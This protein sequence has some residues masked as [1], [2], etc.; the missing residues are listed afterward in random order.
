VGVRRLLVV[1][2]DGLT[3]I[4]PIAVAA[5]LAYQLSYHDQRSRAGL[6]S[7]LVLNRTVLTTEQLKSAF[8]Q[9]DAFDGPRA[10]SPQAVAVMRQIDLGSS[11]LQGVGHISDNSLQ[12]SSVADAGA[13]SVGPYDYVSATSTFFRRNRNLGINPSA[14]L[15]LVSDGSGSTGIIHPSLIFDLTDTGDTVPAGIVGYSTRENIIS[16]GTA[17]D[18]HGVSLPNGGAGGS[19]ELQGHL[20]AWN[21]SPISDAFSYAAIPLSAVT[22]EFDSLARYFVP[23]AVLVGLLGLLLVRR[24]AASY[25]SL[26]ML[27]KAGLKRGEVLTVYQP[28]VELATGRWVGAEALARWRRPNNEWVSPEV[29]VPIAERHGLIQKLTKH[30]IQTCAAQLA[31]FV[32]AHAN[33]FISINISS[34]DLRDPAFVSTLAETVAANG[35]ARRAIHLE[36]TERAEVESEVEAETIRTLRAMGFKVG[37]DDFGIGYSN[38]AYLDTLQVDY[39]KIDRAFVAGLSGGQLGAQIVDHIIDLAV[40]RGLELIAEGVELDVQRTQLLARDVRLG[41]GWLFGKP[42]D[43]ADFE[44]AYCDQAGTQPEPVPLA[45]V[46]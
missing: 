43:F 34:V 22:G 30:V 14:A 41:Q 11:L 7:G 2:R 21:R 25:S 40:S 19:L 4:V 26:P 38:L 36:L 9:L 46:A 24:F 1:L 23:V 6:M 3:V 20:V 8:A 33:F 17:I 29:F 27:L 39:L 32:R 35:I 44:R 5:L 45:G 37:I 18:W 28:I 42:M 12:C 13:V 31:P 10:C 15:L 16:T